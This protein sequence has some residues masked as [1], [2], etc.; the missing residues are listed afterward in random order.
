MM[1]G[2]SHFFS[3]A[4]RACYNDVIYR[5]RQSFVCVTRQNIADSPL[6]KAVTVPPSGERCRLQEVP[7]PCYSIAE[8]HKG[9]QI[10]NI[11]TN[12]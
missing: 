12:S 10:V 3:H 7:F 11:L 9:A 8:L 1:G 5:I 6:Q 2:G 4:S